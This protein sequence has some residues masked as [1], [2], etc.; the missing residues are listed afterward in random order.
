MEKR[1]CSIV[2]MLKFLQAY[3][4][5]ARIREG[6]DRTKY[7]LSRLTAR[8]AYYIWKKGEVRS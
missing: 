7:V 6:I 2:E 1:R 8:P 4:S 3:G 5:G